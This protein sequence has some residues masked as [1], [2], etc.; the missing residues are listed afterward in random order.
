VKW[1]RKIGDFSLPFHEQQVK[2][3]FSFFT[4]S[5]GLLIIGPEPDL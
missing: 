1:K 4:K 5:S 2:K 3:A